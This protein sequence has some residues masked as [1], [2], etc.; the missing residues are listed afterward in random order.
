MSA[1]LGSPLGR[2]LGKGS[3]HSGSHHWIV[4][5]GTALALIVLLPLLVGS[6]LLL[7]DF[8]YDSVRGWIAG[9][10]TAVGLCLAVPILCWHSQLGVQVVIEDYVHQEAVKTVT[11]LLVRATHAVLAVAGVLAVLR[12]TLGSAG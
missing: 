1:H 8:S 9:S 2:V 10:W 5:R 7:P 11:L 12:I 6:A 3:A 4:Q